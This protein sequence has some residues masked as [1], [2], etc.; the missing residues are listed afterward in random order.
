MSFGWAAGDVLAVI[1]LFER[2]IVELRN[3]R[4]APTHFQQLH[5]ELNMHLATIQT[6]LTVEPDMPGQFVIVQRMR[7]I[8]TS[9]QDPLNRLIEKMHSKDKVLGNF[10]ST[11]ALHGVGTRLHWSM[12][13]RGDVEGLRNELLSKMLAINILLGT[14]QL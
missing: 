12:V 1:N 10:R 3:Y 6:V 13:A 2:V 11:A 5:V 8:A 14:L 4:H 7:A 9:C